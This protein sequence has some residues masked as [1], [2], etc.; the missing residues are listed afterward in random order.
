MEEKVRN[1]CQILW[2]LLLSLSVASTAFVPSTATAA[3]EQKDWNM[4]VFL[5]GV[6][7]LDEFGAMNINQMEESGSNDRL[8]ILVQWGSLERPTIDRL[9]VQKD[10]DTNNVTSPIVDS[11]G[12]ADMGDWRELVKFAK[13]ANENYPAKRTFIV[14]WNHGNGWHRV[15]DVFSTKDISFDERTGNA[16]TTEDLGRAMKTI[17]R[18]TGKRVDLYGSD[19]CLMGMV[20]VAEEMSG[21]VDVFLGSQD[22]EPGQGWPYNTFLKAWSQ[23]VDRTPAEVAKLLSKHFLAAYSGGV[24][25]RANVTMSAFDMA[26]LP[27]YRQ[28]VSEV[29]K[30]LARMPR[31]TQK[32]LKSAAKATKFFFNSDYRDLIDF[33]NQ[34]AKKRVMIQSAAE[35]RAAQS[36]FV[37]AND[38]N[39][40]R[41][42][43]GLSIWL[44]TET[45]TY[46]EFKSRYQKMSFDQKTKWTGFLKTM[47]GTRS[48]D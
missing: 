41:N 43:Y 3:P 31:A 38:Q 37:I 4:L 18:E 15:E 35:L 26:K 44:P 36:E 9:L 16:I 13:W 7:N 45:K 40:D 48:D 39:Q 11:R 32:T 46:G 28:A 8:N 1:H 25:G 27:R 6:N 47:L 23:N 42:T 2:G 30:E 12:I 14:V 34:S 24:F 22:L 21:A 17:A 33:I 29:G 10:N 19:A 5:N 20:E